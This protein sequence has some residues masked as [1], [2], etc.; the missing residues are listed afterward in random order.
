MVVQSYERRTQGNIAFL[1][2]GQGSHQVGMGADLYRTYGF[3]K[4]FFKEV[5]EAASAPLMKVAFEGPEDELRKTVN[6]QPAIMAVSLA[7]L[8]VMQNTLEP[9][10]VPHPA[11]AAGHSLGEYTALVAAG[12]LEPLDAV[13]LVRERGR[14]MHDASLQGEGTMAAIIG[15]DEDVLE[16]VCRETGAEIANVNSAEQTV[17]SGERHAVGRAMD[18]A[19]ARGAKRAIL[20]QVGGAFHSSLMEPAV[21]GMAQ[22]LQGMTVQA[23]EIPVIANCTGQPITSADEVRQELASQV[24]SCVQWRRSMSY[25]LDAGITRFVEIGPGRVLSGLVRRM[26]RDVDVVAISDASTLKQLATA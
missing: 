26:S 6:A 17:I 15:L 13:R 14:L 7:C 5:D 3:V 24:R 19:A 18:L 1:F 10:R 22:A 12:A 4:D 23:P 2:P 16:A 25:L 9:E 11:F 8:L 21:E 20:L